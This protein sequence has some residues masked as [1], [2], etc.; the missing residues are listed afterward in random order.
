[1]TPGEKVDARI[2]AVTA[3]LE[4]RLQGLFD[5]V[6]GRWAIW[7]AAAVF[8]GAC[9]DVG[10]EALRSLPASYPEFVVGRATILGFGK[11]GDY[12]MLLAFVLG[13]AA[14]FTLLA[15]LFK[16]VSA[17]GGPDTAEEFHR[18]Y[19]IAVIPLF[20]WAATFI[21]PQGLNTSL[22]WAALILVL[23]T[24]AGAAL[25]VARRTNVLGGS[26]QSALYLMDAIVLIPMATLFAVFA[27]GMVGNRIGMLYG[28]LWFGRIALLHWIVLAAILAAAAGVALLPRIVTS[29]EKRSA[30]LRG[31][32]IGLQVLL[33]GLVLVILPMP[34]GPVDNRFSYFQTVHAGTWV[35][36]GL[37]A[38]CTWADLVRLWRKGN[39]AAPAAMVS[40][41]SLIA[42]LIY[43]RIQ[44]MAVLGVPFDDYHAGED[45]VPWWSWIEHGMIPLWDFTPP[46]GLI[47]Y[48]MGALAALF[49]DQTAAGLI[50]TTPYHM[51][52]LLL[53]AVP[54]VAAV[55]G[56]WPTFLL[57]L[58][59]NLDERL[60]DIDVLM[61]AAFCLLVY[62]WAKCGHVRWLVLWVILGITVVLIAPGQG[63]LLV[64]A[65]IPG[66]LW[67][68]Y[69][70]VTEQRRDLLRIGGIA[71]AVLAVLALATPLGLMIAGAIRYGAGQSSVNGIANGL[72]WDAGFATVANVN[73][74]L[75]EIMRFS[76]LGVGAAAIVM[77]MWAWP[78][79]RKDN[80]RVL[81]IGST[82]AII[83]LL[84]ILRSGARLDT[85]FIGRPGWTS[86][87]ALALLFPLLLG[88]LLQGTKRMWAMIF[89]AAGA[90]TMTANF[91]IF[92]LDWALA[93]PFVVQTP[94]LEASYIKGADSGL[95][96][97]GVVNMPKDDVARLG[98]VKRRLDRLLT[99]SETFLDLT[100]RGAQYFYFDRPPPSDVSSFYNMIT[101]GQ[102]RR[103][104]DGV[105]KKKVPVALIGASNEIL[106]GVPASQR[107][108]LV[109]RH[110]LLN[111]VPAALDSYDYMLLPERLEQA[112]L[113]AA[114]PLEPTEEALEIL[115]RNFFLPFQLD[116]IPMSF[117]RSVGTLAKRMRPVVALDSS[118]V[119][120][121][122][123]G[124]RTADGAYT[125]IGSSPAV[126]FDLTR[127]HLHGR[128]AG[129]LRFDYK[130]KNRKA[131]STLA[132]RWISERSE[133]WNGTYMEFPAR[134][135]TFIVPLDTAPRWLLANAISSL[136]IEMVK[137]DG[138][139]AFTLEN[140]TLL[141]RKEVDEMEQALRTAKND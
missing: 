120:R 62:A 80:G 132:V 1:M 47:N 6:I 106:D 42:V 108:P 41:L 51:I 102:Q 135:G 65:T 98:T 110:L 28:P 84:Y 21:F 116:R 111:F 39:G 46:R 56:L 7:L 136:N 25:V 17:V 129:L 33:P 117:G 38:L 141:Q 86:M 10:Y 134:D 61:T 139:T 81:F 32:V 128:D 35:F 67:R 79:A 23:L 26:P 31:L 53:I 54:A 24:T 58:S 97:L 127:A 22:F 137:A 85:G 16:R 68:L 50:A 114:Q 49:T 60:G 115:D 93:R 55:I 125:V 107:T 15:A 112:G 72:L 78:A 5:A 113:P 131:K 77:T 88:T 126:S 14:F 123:D 19:V 76:W 43:I 64:M 89:C 119:P 73:A 63:A 11:A 109:Y 34:V 140:V 138:C 99:P 30:V 71:A 87:W 130:C 36:L 103:A 83:C 4:D 105:V 66:G 82:I 101:I 27:V 122:T 18:R 91:G 44:P 75:V 13:T 92:G 124:T 40:V 118:Y 8:G 2:A 37:Y 59:A 12:A 74:W 48:K 20:A 3:F 90:A 52:I 94:P 57:F 133:P 96:N 29:H 95:P 69:K 9:A 70:A 104:V 45:F 121:V 100:N